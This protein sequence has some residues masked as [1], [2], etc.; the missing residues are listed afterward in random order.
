MQYR[1]RNRLWND[2]ERK[3]I[4]GG[5]ISSFSNIVKYTESMSGYFTYR[6]LLRSS[7][8][9]TIVVPR[10]SKV[11]CSNGIYQASE[12]TTILTSLTSISDALLFFYIHFMC[13]KKQANRLYMG[14][15]L[16]LFSFL[17]NAVVGCRGAG[18]NHAWRNC[19]CGVSLSMSVSVDLF[20]S[21]FCWF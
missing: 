19:L 4:S 1:N 2:D 5:N 21:L 3:Y 15:L 7:A 8:N 14:L 18:V 9:P 17:E 10:A 20:W 6:S 16:W 13:F 12:D 11:I